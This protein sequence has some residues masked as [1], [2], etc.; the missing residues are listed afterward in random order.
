MKYIVTLELGFV[1]L[2]RKAVL[3]VKH[4]S[5]KDVSRV[6]CRARM[7]SLLLVQHCGINA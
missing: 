1:T 2:G 7:E 5:D 3:H 6:F 4:T